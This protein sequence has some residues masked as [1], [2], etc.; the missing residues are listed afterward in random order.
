MKDGAHWPIALAWAAV[1]ASKLLADLAPSAA[2]AHSP[3]GR[4]VT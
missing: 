3:I 1:E 4:A 2:E